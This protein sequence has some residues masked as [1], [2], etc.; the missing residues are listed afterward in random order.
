VVTY[1]TAAKDV[2]VGIWGLF[3]PTTGIDGLFYMVAIALGGMALA[4]VISAFRK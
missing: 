4:A 3:N 1:I 2:L